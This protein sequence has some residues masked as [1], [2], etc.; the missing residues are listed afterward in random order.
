MAIQS[1]ESGRIT[2]R[3]LCRSTRTFDA[4]RRANTAVGT[5]VETS[6]LFLSTTTCTSFS[7]SRLRASW[8]NRRSPSIAF[9]HCYLLFYFDISSW[10]TQNRMP[11]NSNMEFFLLSTLILPRLLAPINVL[12]RHAT[13]AIFYKRFDD[14]DTKGQPRHTFSLFGELWQKIK[15]LLPIPLENKL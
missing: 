13:T 1:R 6:F 5:T 12:W 14:D 7:Q 15:L 9:P 10:S 8:W 2:A 3:Y 11:S 4:T